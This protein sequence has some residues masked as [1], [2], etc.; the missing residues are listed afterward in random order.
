MRGQLW[1][2]ETLQLPLHEPL[3]RVLRR[4]KSARYAHLLARLVSLDPCRVEVPPPRKLAL[5]LC[6]VHLELLPVA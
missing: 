5:T 6:P 2:I 4:G 1:R 3:V